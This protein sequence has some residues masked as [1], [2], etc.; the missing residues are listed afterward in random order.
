MRRGEGVWPNSGGVRLS[1]A[2]E[3]W[4]RAGG[5]LVCRMGGMAVPIGEKGHRQV[6]PRVQCP[7]LISFKPIK[8]I[9]TLLNLNFKLVRTLID[10]KI[11]FPCL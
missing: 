7:G 5:A 4:A 11:T 10:Q 9:Q 2:L 3:Q 8:S 6:G 1:P